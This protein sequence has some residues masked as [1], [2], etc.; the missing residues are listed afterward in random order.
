MQKF[1]IS[2][3]FS[4]GPA[5]YVSNSSPISA[6]PI[7]N[8][9]AWFYNIQ[10]L[11]DRLVL[12]SINCPDQLFIPSL[13]D[14]FK[15]QHVPSGRC[16][17]FTSGSDGNKIMFKAACADEF[18][19]DANGGLKHVASSAC[20]FLENNEKFKMSST[21]CDASDVAIMTRSASGK[22][23]LRD[24][25]GIQKHCAIPRATGAE[26]DMLVN[27][28]CATSQINFRYL[29]RKYETI[30]FEL[31]SYFYRENL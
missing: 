23:L 17:S 24:S 12:H 20:A 18:T 1:G 26:D 29:R 5:E 14:T 11:S 4:G 7:R 19:Y 22:L 3:K 8:Q 28:S 13:K 15:I 6:P 27:G 2:F 10:F 21:K 30:K 25:N 31:V 16:L 9:A